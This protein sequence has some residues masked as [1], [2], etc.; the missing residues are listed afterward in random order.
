[1]LFRMLSGGR[2][3]HTHLVVGANIDDNGEKGI[4]G[5][6]SQAGAESQ[7]T[8]WNAHS[9][10]AQVAQTEDSLPIGNNNGL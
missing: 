9:E 1:M 7:F 10:A 6:A 5:N 4:G 2:R 8:H 3:E